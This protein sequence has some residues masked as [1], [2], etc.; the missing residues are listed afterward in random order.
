MNDENKVNELAVLYINKLNQQG[1]F[2]FRTKKSEKNSFNVK[3]MA[4]C[5]IKRNGVMFVDFLII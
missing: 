2:S 1:D 4:R 3:F 5:E